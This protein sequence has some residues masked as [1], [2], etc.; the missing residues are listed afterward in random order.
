MSLSKNEIKKNSQA[1]I[2]SS[3]R[4]KMYKNN[5]VAIFKINVFKI[6]VINLLLVV[7]LPL[8]FSKSEL[9]IPSHF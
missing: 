1:I 5:F 6:Y 4:P 9:P 8:V 7:S 2:F 3:W